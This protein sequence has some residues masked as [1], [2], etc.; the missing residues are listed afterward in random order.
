MGFGNTSGAFVLAAALAS[1]EI[2]RSELSCTNGFRPCA[3]LLSMS[4]AM[5]SKAEKQLL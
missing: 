5:R 4:I 3:I 1:D 2:L